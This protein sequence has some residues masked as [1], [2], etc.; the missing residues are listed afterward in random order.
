M[1]KILS[2]STA[3]VLLAGCCCTGNSGDFELSQNRAQ[4]SANT[5]E[6]FSV[7][8]ESNPTTGYGWNVSVP[9]GVKMLAQNYIPDNSAPNLCGAGGIEKFDFVVPQKGSY[10]IKFEYRRP[11]EK[12][13]PA[14]HTRTLQ[15][16]AK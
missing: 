2:I 5:S 1:L 11:W 10:E 6:Q 16:D 8:L 9:D 15:V 7:V 12:N 14:L 3:A 13:V 4:I